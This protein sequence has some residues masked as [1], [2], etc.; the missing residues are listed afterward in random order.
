LNR[1]TYALPPIAALSVPDAMQSVSDAL[2]LKGRHH[3][4]RTS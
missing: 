3:S 2:E 4:H 1:I